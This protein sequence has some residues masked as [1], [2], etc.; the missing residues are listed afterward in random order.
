MFGARHERFRLSMI[1]GTIICLIF[2]LTFTNALQHFS[3]RGQ[4]SEHI[5]SFGDRMVAWDAVLNM[6]R[7][8]MQTL[9]G[10]GIAMKFVPIEGHYWHKQVLDSSWF[11]AFVQTGLIGVAITVAMVI[12]AATQALRNARP[13]K[14]LW[15][16]LVVLVV[17]RSIL[18]SGLLDTSTSFIVFMIISMGAA[19]Q[20]H[21]KSSSGEKRF[22]A[23][24]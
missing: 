6:N 17:I 2:A 8:L 9:F 23:R 7:P 15:L 4:S 22:H 12:Y 18:E 10:Q 3:S 13:A 21:L 19:T 14:D 1:T 20:A 24:V 16:A 11:S 5:D